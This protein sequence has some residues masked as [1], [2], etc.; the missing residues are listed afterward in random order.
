[1]A[2]YHLLTYFDFSDNR[3]FGFTLTRRADNTNPV[4]VIIIESPDIY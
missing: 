3:P 4:T 2:E 1:M